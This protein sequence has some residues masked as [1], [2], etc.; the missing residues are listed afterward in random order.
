MGIPIL[1]RQH[2]YIETVSLSFHQTWYTT[3]YHDELRSYDF[4]RYLYCDEISLEADSVLATLYAAK[5]YIMPHLEQACVEYLETNVDASN[6]CLLLSQC[7]IFDEPELQQSCLD[8]IDHRAEDALKS[9]SFTEIDHQTLEQILRRD[10][11][12]VE[13]TLVFAAA[14][15]WA[16]AECTRQWRDVNP[17]QCREVLGHA[18]YL[19][20]F[21]AMTLNEFANTAGQSGILSKDELI[22]IFFFF[23]ADKKPELQFPVHPRKPRNISAC[24]RFQC[25]T[26]EWCFTLGNNNS[27]QF[28]VDKAIT[29]IGFGLYGSISAEEYHVDIVLKQIDG[30]VLRKK[31]LKM[32]FD[33]SSNTTP[34]LFDRAI[35]IESDIFYTASFIVDYGGRGHYG[36]SGMPH[37]NCDGI[38]FK[39]IEHP[40]TANHTTVLQGQIPE[41]LFYHWLLFNG[42]LT[43]ISHNANYYMATHVHYHRYPFLTSGSG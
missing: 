41:I 26:S 6:A 9:N 7:R 1:V 4:C 30:V 34:V 35:Q 18:L 29:V 36:A 20:R 40:I 3:D 42:N 16:E 21:P 12:R 27:I 2:F 28:T 43:C 24:S 22:A 31:Q 11:L 39:F 32:S 14:T 23:S 8:V 38:N 33:G 25:S 15:R 17:E 37:V 10:T 13:E 5:K 19:L